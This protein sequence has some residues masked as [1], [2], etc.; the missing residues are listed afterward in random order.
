MPNLTY[1][2]VYDNAEQRDACWK[3][4][5]SDPGQVKRGAKSKGDAA[6]FEGLAVGYIIAMPR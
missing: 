1:M 4:F 6:L 5:Q 3:E 2:A